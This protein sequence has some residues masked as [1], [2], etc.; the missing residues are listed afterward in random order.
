[1][2]DSDTNA[3][4]AALLIVYGYRRFFRQLAMVMLVCQSCGNP[5]AHALRKLVTWF[6]LFF[7]PLFPC[8]PTRYSIQCTFCGMQNRLSKQQAL[9][10][11]AQDEQMRQQPQYPGGYPA[12]QPAQLPQPQFGQPPHSGGFPV[13]QNPYPPG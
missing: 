2:G 4:K 1:M 3:A 12:Q 6:T 8:A 11:T 5:A 9:Q 13:Q 10:L 7:I